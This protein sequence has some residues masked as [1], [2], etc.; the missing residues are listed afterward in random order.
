MCAEQHVVAHGIFEGCCLVVEFDSMLA[1]LVIWEEGRGTLCFSSLTK[2]L[3][4]YFRREHEWF[5]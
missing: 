5:E 4:K 2:L 1:M 3:R